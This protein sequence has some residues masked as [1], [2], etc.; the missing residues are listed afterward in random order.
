MEKTIR[1]LAAAGVLMLLA[2]GAF[3]SH[4]AVG[5]CG[6]DLGRGAR[7]PGGGA[8]LQRQGQRR[9]SARR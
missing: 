8:E 1:L 7:L 4:T 6:A 9:P 5:L 2:G 3:C